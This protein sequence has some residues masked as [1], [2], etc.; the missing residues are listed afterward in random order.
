MHDA[1]LYYVPVRRVCLLLFLLPNAAS[2]IVAG[3]SNR[4]PDRLDV[5]HITRKDSTQLDLEFYGR[6][7]NVKPP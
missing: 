4:L 2:T 6:G 1:T 5:S 3:F 7:N